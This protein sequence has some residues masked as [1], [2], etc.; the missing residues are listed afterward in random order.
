[1]DQRLDLHE[2]LSAYTKLGAYAEF[3]ETKKGMLKEGY[4][5]DLIILYGAIDQLESAHIQEL[6]VELTM[7]DGHI[8]SKKNYYSRR[9][10]W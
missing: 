10:F 6:E 4:F 9:N 5:A 1:M 2:T 3:K 8:V 7:E